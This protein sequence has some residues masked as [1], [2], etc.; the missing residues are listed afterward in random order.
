MR[1][2]PVRK[3]TYSHPTI[4]THLFDIF[5]LVWNGMGGTDKHKHDSPVLVLF[6]PG[7]FHSLFM[8]SK[9][10]NSPKIFENFG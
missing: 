3:L 7:L 2:I 6:L 8:K 9:R 5:V 10:Q 1:Y 4:E